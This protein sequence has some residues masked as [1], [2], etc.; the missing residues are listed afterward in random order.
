M[1]YL[2]CPF[3]SPARGSED[4]DMHQLQLEQSWRSFAQSLVDGTG[5]AELTSYVGQVAG[6]WECAPVS[7]A[8]MDA[9][10]QMVLLPNR[11]IAG[12]RANPGPLRQ[13]FSPAG[14]P[15]AFWSLGGDSRLVCPSGPGDFPQLHAWANTPGADHAALWRLVGL[16]LQAWWSNT[17]EP[18]W[19][20]THGLGVPWL[21]VRL[22]PRPK[23]IHHARFRALPS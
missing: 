23:Y 17:P 8:T 15:V 10:V 1:V 13:Y 21:H 7:A 19:L 4:E 3:R 11:R 22:D 2:P 5:S 18:L 16:E 9:P 14:E 12:L 6:L 20:S